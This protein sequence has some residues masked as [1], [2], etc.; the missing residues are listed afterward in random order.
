MS[1]SYTSTMYV[2]GTSGGSLKS[3]CAAQPE[4]MRYSIM[5]NGTHANHGHGK[6][7]AA[8][9]CHFRCGNR[10]INTK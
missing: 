4:S 6:R 3:R 10:D 7:D 8:D 2:G 9:I 5:L 1:E